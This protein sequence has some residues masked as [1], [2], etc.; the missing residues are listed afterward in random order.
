MRTSVDAVSE[1]SSIVEIG[2]TI[3]VPSLSVGALKS[4]THCSHAHG[5]ASGKGTKKTVRKCI[6][7]IDIKKKSQQDAMRSKPAESFD[8]SVRLSFRIGR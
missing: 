3:S 7:E 1:I 8:I 5:G 6:M 2:P 4:V